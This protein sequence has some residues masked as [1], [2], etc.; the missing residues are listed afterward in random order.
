MT[1]RGIIV[2]ILAAGKG[3]RMHSDLPK[4][5]HPLA[6]RP[7]IQYL[8]H[9]VEGLEPERVVVIV[10]PG[11]ES[12]ARAV[13]PHWTLIQSHRLG[14]GHAVAATR[15][16]LH[17]FNGE[18]LV[19]C[20]DVPLLPRAALSRMLSVIRAADLQTCLVVLGFHPKNPAGYGRLI[21]ASDGS[22]CAIVE[23][24]EATPSQQAM[25]L[26]NAGAIV[27]RSEY[28]FHLLSA[29]GNNNAAREYY[30]TDIV[31][32]A[33]HNGLSCS[34]VETESEAVELFGIN[35]QRDLARAEAFMQEQLRGAML[36][37]GV[38]LVDPLTVHC[39]FDT[40]IGR[41]VIIHPYV[42]FGS[43]VTIEDNVEI[44]S[45]CHLEQSTV[46]AG[47]RIGPY[48]RLRPGAKIHAN[49]HIGNFVEI[50]SS[51]VEH[52]AKVNHLS[53]IGNGRVGAGAN[54][55][56]GTIFCNYDGYVKASTDVGAGAFIGSNSALVAPVK[57]GDGA[58]I[59]AGSVITK[60]VA[61]NALAVARCLQRERPGWASLRHNK[62][63][64]GKTAQK[65]RIK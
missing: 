60:D 56:A 62:T 21:T 54:I 23:H 32:V 41:N 30:L 12:V 3:T 38:T 18:I 61:D 33:T 48:A 19:L 1:Q 15:E 42:V 57:I 2:V 53:Y 51:V 29:V 45:F 37:S 34:Y 16:L 58:I 13:A 55:G 22:L 50:K 40:K 44:Q 46:S 25:G 49:A 59:G 27:V 65:R 36:D 26:C 63:G 7:M 14:T 64:E 10:G 17:E 20:G 39:C 52:G 31:A 28:L 6:G 9:T 47:A 8:I 11:M 24:Q 5:L 35:T 4:V 43:G